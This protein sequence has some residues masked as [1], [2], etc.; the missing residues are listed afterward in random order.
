MR[1]RLPILCAAIACHLLALGVWALLPRTG[2]LG[3]P[4]PAI[5]GRIRLPFDASLSNIP[6]PGPDPGIQVPTGGA[7]A[8]TPS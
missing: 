4:Q 8:E 3:E 2:G 5:E 6:T 7:A 1:H